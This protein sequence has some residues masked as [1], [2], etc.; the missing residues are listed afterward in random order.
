MYEFTDKTFPV[1]V[2]DVRKRNMEQ[3]LDLV[4]VSRRSSRVAESCAESSA[5]SGRQ[6]YTLSAAGKVA[7]LKLT[8]AES[9]LSDRQDLGRLARG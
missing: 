3:H 5:A 7:L 4:D 2:E 6:V 9:E 8:A 1:F